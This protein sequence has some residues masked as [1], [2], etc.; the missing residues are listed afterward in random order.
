MPDPIRIL[1]ASACPPGQPNI[2]VDAELQNLREIVRQQRDRLTLTDSIATSFDKFHRELIEGNFDIV[3]ISAHG[4]EESLLLEHEDGREQ[5]V[6]S[7]IL[8]EILAQQ[9]H[10]RCVVLNACWSARWFERPMA[11]A[12]VLMNGEVDDEAALGFSRGFYEALAAGRTTSEAFTAGRLRGLQCRQGHFDPQ[13]TSNNQGVLGVRTLESF[14]PAIAEHSEFTCDLS[15]AFHAD[16][17]VDWGEAAAKIHAFAHKPDILQR[18]AVADS[19]YQ[20]RLACHGSVAFMLGREFGRE[21]PLF[22]VQGRIKPELWRVDTNAESDDPDW[23]VTE[24]G[25]PGASILA[26]AVSLAQ[27]TGP[28]VLRHFERLGSKAHIFEFSVPGPEGRNVR[29][30]NHAAML[31]RSLQRKLDEIG[32]RAPDQPLHL[33]MSAPNGFAFLLGKRG[34]A[35]LGMIQLYEFDPGTRTYAPSILAR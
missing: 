9:A 32:H 1:F 29:S 18:L 33:F 6:D 19:E 13:L 7:R 2:R 15:H 26:F 16:G 17:G 21:A 11:P 23:Q 35:G 4:S 27:P 8:T 24:H 10:L 22:P 31:A 3:H 28:A 34:R 25:D 12:M 5:P 14:A 20:I 30:G